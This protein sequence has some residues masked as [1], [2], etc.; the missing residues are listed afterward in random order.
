MKKILRSPI[1]YFGGKGNFVKKILPFIPRH[2]VYV[3]VF[4]GGASLL[5]AKEPSPV[6]VYNDIWS[7]V[8]NFF[9]VLRDDGIFKKF[10][11]FVIN[12]PYSREEFYWCNEHYNE[13]KDDVEKAW[14][15]FVLIRQSFSGG[16]ANSWSYTINYSN[17]N[18]TASNS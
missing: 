13:T 14:V 5:F 10:Y 9:R 8:V 18:M 12:T 4:G 15:F 6:E 16:F 7:D 2:R 17:K 11:N 1:Q 3:E